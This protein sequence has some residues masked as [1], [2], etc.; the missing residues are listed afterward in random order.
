MYVA[1]KLVGTE[2][3]HLGELFGTGY[4]WI[5]TPS[6]MTSLTVA[7]QVGADNRDRI[8]LSEFTMFR[9]IPGL[10][11]RSFLNKLIPKLPFYSMT[12]STQFDSTKW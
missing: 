12:F 4:V 11:G 9:K 5:F 6:T 8:V 2:N 1:E 10:F 3:E 7:D